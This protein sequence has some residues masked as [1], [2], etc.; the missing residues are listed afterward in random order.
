M[1]GFK[2]E[3]KVGTLVRG[4]VSKKL[5]VRGVLWREAEIEVK[6]AIFEKKETAESE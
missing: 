5:A 2:K 6:G 1:G 3:T 4:R